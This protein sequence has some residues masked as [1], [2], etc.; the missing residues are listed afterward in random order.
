MDAVSFPE[1]GSVLP[2]LLALGA[3]FAVAFAIAFVG[4]IVASPIVGLLVLAVGLRLAWRTSPSVD[5]GR[6]RFLLGLGAA[7]VGA[8]AAGSAVGRVTLRATRPAAGPDL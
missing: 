1:R 8:V 2:T 7:G 3:A 5:E 4:S 6:R